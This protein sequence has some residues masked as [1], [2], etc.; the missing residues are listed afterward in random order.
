MVDTYRR[1]R[2]QEFVQNPAESERLFEEMTE[3]RV[4]RSALLKQLAILTW[5]REEL[6]SLEAI[7]NQE[8]F[9]INGQVQ[10]VMTDIQQAEGSVHATRKQIQGVKSKI[11]KAETSSPIWQ[12]RKSHFRLSW[13]N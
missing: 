11:A 3:L 6:A 1:T 10:D 8:I 2:T 7:F 9:D 13:W 5:R 4:Q 12:I